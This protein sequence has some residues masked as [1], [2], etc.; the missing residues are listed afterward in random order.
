MPFEE[1]LGFSMY[2]VPQA[3][4]PLTPSEA[5]MVV[6]RDPATN[7]SLLSSKMGISKFRFGNCPLSKVLRS[8]DRPRNHEVDQ[9]PGVRTRQL[10]RHLK[11]QHLHQ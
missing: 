8:R 5:K 9:R 3:R 1:V 4:R 10:K 2:F 6:Y 7:R 11:S